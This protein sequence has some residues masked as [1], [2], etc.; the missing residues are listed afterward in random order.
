MNCSSGKKVTVKGFASLH[1]ENTDTQAKHII[2]A[3]I[4]VNNFLNIF[5]SNFFFRLFFHQHYILFT[6]IMSIIK[7]LCINV[8]QTNKQQFIPIYEKE[9]LNPFKVIEIKYL[10]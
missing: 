8:I 6:N 9:L 10:I 3:T 1:P 5:A 4:M 7:I 2:T